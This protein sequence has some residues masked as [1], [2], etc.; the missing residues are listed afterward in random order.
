MK[1][2][3]VIL[4]GYLRF[5]RTNTHVFRWTPESTEQIIL[6]TNGSG[7]S[8][9]L[10][11]LITL[12][13]RGMNKDFKP[14]G[15]YDIRLE[16]RGSKYRLYGIYNS[17][18]GKHSF[19][20]NDGED[21]NDGNTQATQRELLYEHF[22]I[23]EPIGHILTGKVRFSQMSVTQRREWLMLMSGVDFD[24][25][26]KMYEYFA[27]SQRDIKGYLK[28]VTDVLDEQ[29][30]EAN[31]LVYDIEATEARVE[32]VRRELDTLLRASI[33]K[34]GMCSEDLMKRLEDIAEDVKQIHHETIG[35]MGEE[36]PEGVN[37]SV[38]E[39]MGSLPSMERLVVTYRTKIAGHIE[40]M[41]H[42]T[43]LAH[44]MGLTMGS[45]AATSEQGL[46]DK[47]LALNEEN[48]HLMSSVRRWSGEKDNAAVKHQSALAVRPQLTDLSTRLIPNDKGQFTRAGRAELEQRLQIANDVIF[49]LKDRTS[50]L[51][52][53]IRNAE[54]V[55][56]VNCP[57]CAN[58]F[59]PGVNY[60]QLE[61]DKEDLAFSSERLNKV[62]AEKK[63]YEE[64]LEA[65]REY[66]E[67]WREWITL[68]TGSPMIRE[69][70]LV[71]ADEDVAVKTPQT[72]PAR[73]ERYIY[74]LDFLRQVNQNETQI[75]TLN[76][77][78]EALRNAGGGEFIAKRVAEMEGELIRMEEDCAA[79]VERVDA[80][81][82]VIKRYEQGM[83]S[84]TSLADC[85]V[86]YNNQVAGVL[87]TM[88]GEEIENQ[89]NTRQHDLA[90]MTHRANRSRA[91]MLSIENSKKEKESAEESLE[92][93]KLVTQSLSPKDGVIA[94]A[95]R[96]FATYFSDLLN[97]HISLV[98]TYDMIV[99][100][101]IED[102]AMNCK[103]PM[104]VSSIG[105]PVDDVADGSEGQVEMVDF[106]FV[107]VLM[108][109]LGLKD[110]PLFVDEFGRAFDQEHRERLITYIK[111]L[112][113]SG[114]YSQLF[115]ISHYASVYGPFTQAEFVVL[116]TRN[117]TVPEVY[118]QNVT[119]E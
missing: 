31:D 41:G 82:S 67:V 44:D 98:W 111:S 50:R 9:F 59:K 62:M 47:I 97:E 99:S 4:I 88:L 61:R 53:V 66:A 17:K 94:D 51:E 118:N 16:H 113:D 102:A 40:Q 108:D 96:N 71:M 100:A 65:Y 43:K 21:M 117:I 80:I 52:N 105:D 24:Y 91:L 5:Q 103:F 35:W 26:E 90:E 48:A 22:G 86:S 76:I 32:V 18:A 84:I 73:L 109:L 74:E 10:Q 56:E 42:F 11:L 95:I 107:L 29:I 58:T 37:E 30:S 1:I 64:K 83:R 115:M 3:E 49:E 119:M 93:Y 87:R 78:L 81:R 69:F 8:S 33:R 112:V 23:N 13:G 92:S 7:K 57:Q 68:T 54:H 72:L 45:D 38:E 75:E 79:A 25:I 106:A 2:E 36:R 89:I 55:C 19:W 27:E 104:V 28:R 34:E 77:R 6:G 70:W 39:L 15:S 101:V 110:H 63:E 114:R 14:G 60:G 46:H 116:D 12:I 20:M 85:E